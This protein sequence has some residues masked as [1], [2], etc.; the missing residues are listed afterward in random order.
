MFNSADYDNFLYKNLYLHHI[1]ILY[2]YI[3]FYS[4]FVILLRKKLKGHY[5]LKILNF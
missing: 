1:I 3:I 4:Y 2:H 5:F